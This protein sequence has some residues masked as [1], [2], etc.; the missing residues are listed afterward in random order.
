M[1]STSVALI[2][3]V[4]VVSS[5]VVVSS[6]NETRMPPSSI[7][8]TSNQSPPVRTLASVN[9][10]SSSIMKSSYAILPDSLYVAS[11]KA[12][13]GVSKL[14]SLEIILRVTAPVTTFLPPATF[15]PRSEIIL[16]SAASFMYPNASNAITTS[17]GSAVVS[18]L[19]N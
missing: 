6:I 14:T 12:V 19:A 7:T 2:V 11:V 10:S 17:A 16:S 8:S 9:S 1:P 4:L 18:M 3:T 13:A 15:S 5:V